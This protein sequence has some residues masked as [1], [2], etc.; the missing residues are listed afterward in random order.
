V[1]VSSTATPIRRLE[2][3]PA[4]VPARVRALL[5]LDPLL[6]VAAVGVVACSLITLHVAA[7]GQDPGPSFYVDRQAIYAV[8][9]L[10][11]AIGLALFDYSLLRRY[12]YVLYGA[13]IA[14]NLVVL[15]MPAIN[16]GRRWIPLPLFEFQSSEFGKILLIVSL[17]AFLVERARRLHEW[18]TTL[19]I[20]LLALLPAA[21]V[22]A[23]PDLGTSLVY[24]VVGFMVLFVGGTPWKQLTALAAVA[25]AAIALILAG[26][27]L[28]VHVLKSYQQQRLTTFINPPQVCNTQKDTTCYQ[29]NESLTAIGSGEKTGRGAVGA[30]Q[31]EL[32]YLPAPTT[33]FVFAA[34]GE[35][36]G[37][38]GAALL[39]SLYALLIWRTLRILMTAKNLYGTVIAGGILGMFM[40]QIFVSVGMTLGIMPT[41]GVPLPLMTYGGSSV[42]VT[43]IAIGL[44]Q[45]IHVQ[46]RMANAS[47]G[48]VQ[49]S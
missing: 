17:G 47:K 6:M 31:T 18:R 46:G 36:Y 14:L 24:V 32:G 22:T 8:V 19:R 12:R 1:S 4:A 43:F 42:I 25:V 7:R 44:L 34:L 49:I 35:T 13:M 16:G 21:I 45:S 28:G 39:L 41:T 3:K 48:R 10:F 37:F 29:L 2:E 27:S 23:Q 38:V 26:P 30:T 5:T 9:G 11:V 15:G 20:M 40:F 33:D